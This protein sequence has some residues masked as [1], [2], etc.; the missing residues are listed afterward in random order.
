MKA[1]ICPF[2]KEECLGHGCTMWT[3]IVGKHPQTGQEVNQFD[4]SIKWFPLMLLENA[5]QTRGVQAA[6][7]SMRNEIVQRQD[8]LNNA[9]AL[10]QRRTQQIEN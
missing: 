8:T 2:L 4:C 9:I 6:T 5:K 1:P 7:E 3:N 10:A